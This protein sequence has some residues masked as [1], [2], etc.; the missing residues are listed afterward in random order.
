MTDT[1]WHEYLHKLNQN[2]QWGFPGKSPDEM[3]DFCY[4]QM[5]ERYPGTYAMPW[6]NQAGGFKIYMHFNDP[7]E[8]LMWKLRWS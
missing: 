1:P 8:E 4:K 6:V 3:A 5:Q 2:F 7:E